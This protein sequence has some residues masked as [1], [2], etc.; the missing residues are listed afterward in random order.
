MS[1]YNT[2]IDYCET[3]LFTSEKREKT[4]KI[5]KNG[6]NPRN[7]FVYREYLPRLSTELRK[8]NRRSVV[9]YSFN[10]KKRMFTN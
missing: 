9:F 3:L 2:D 6:I 8:A 1:M 5:K 4:K 10:Q 7:G